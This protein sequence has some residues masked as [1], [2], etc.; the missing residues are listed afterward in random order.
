MTMMS[1]IRRGPADRE[2]AEDFLLCVEMIEAG[3][4][5]IYD[6]KTGDITR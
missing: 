4:E 6:V 2:A 1:V 3:I 5:G